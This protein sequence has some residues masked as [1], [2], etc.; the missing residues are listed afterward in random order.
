MNA[1]LAPPRRNALY[2]SLTRTLGLSARDLADLGGYKSDRYPRDLLKGLRPFPQDIQNALLD[3][4]EDVEVITD[5]LVL[6]VEEGDGAI[7]VFGT[8][9]EL[10]ENFPEWPGRGKAAGGFAGP[11]RIAALTA[12]EILKE[13]GIDVDILFYE[14]EV[15][16]SIQLDDE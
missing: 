3:I 9:A 5:T 7:F 11:H 4:Q 14:T 2:A 15:E 1:P 6:Q 16:V 8:N 12:R 10:R 13:R